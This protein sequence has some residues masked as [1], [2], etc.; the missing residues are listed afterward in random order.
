MSGLN[1]LRKYMFKKIIIDLLI[2]LNILN[3]LFYNIFY[4]KT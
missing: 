4:E 1:Y 3:L 2:I